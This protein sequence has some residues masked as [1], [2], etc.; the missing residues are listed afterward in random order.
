MP[1][2]GQAV[3]MVDPTPALRRHGGIATRRMLLAAGCSGSDLTRA[4]RSARIRRVRR[5]WYAALDADPEALLAVR[6][7][8]RLGGPSAARSYGLWAGHDRRLH[9]ALRPNAARLRTNHPPSRRPAVLTPDVSGRAMVLHWV[10][11]EAAAE[12][13]PWRVPLRECLRQMLRWCDRETALACLDTARQQGLLS[14]AE[15]L[16]L[17]RDGS[18][19]AAARMLALRAAPG[20]DSGLESIV[21]QRLD[22]AGVGFRQQV[23]IAEVGR[24]DLLLGERVVVELD[25]AAW[26]GD[27]AAAE[28][29][30][31]RDALLQAK[32]YRVLR[33]SY[34]QVVEEWGFV[35]RMI[36]AV[37]A[38]ESARAP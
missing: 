18:L 26:H 29:D 13:E 20:S 31:R 2:G 3:G 36:R 19:P 7:G 12:V 27:W 35:L 16:E 25:G 10:E 32:G 34:R 8:G 5:G 9:V 28:R 1:P 4:V 38:Q 11:V 14:E 22:S 23:E 24:V 6:V 21:R 30:R 17:G 37:L 15:V 33:F